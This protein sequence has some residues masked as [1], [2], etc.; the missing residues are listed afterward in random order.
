MNVYPA[1][2]SVATTEITR[3]R[4]PRRRQR[5]AAAI[6]TNLIRAADR[7]ARRQQRPQRKPFEPPPRSKWHPLRDLRSLLRGRQS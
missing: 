7:R 4:D 2:K 5:L 1:S 6:A 3:E